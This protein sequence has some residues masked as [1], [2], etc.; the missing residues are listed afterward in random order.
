MAS[1]VRFAPDRRRAIVD[2]P[3]GTHVSLRIARRHDDLDPIRGVVYACLLGISLWALIFL[4][5]F[6]WS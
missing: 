1:Q 5:W 3:Q 2:T 4:A 6:I